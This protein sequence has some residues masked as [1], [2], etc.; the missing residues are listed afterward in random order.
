MSKIAKPHLYARVFRHDRYFAYLLLPPEVDHDIILLLFHL[1]S[2][3]TPAPYLSRY[4]FEFLVLIIAESSGFSQAL[5]KPLT[6]TVSKKRKKRCS[7][8]API[9]Y[10]PPEPLPSLPASLQP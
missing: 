7:V 8:R 9:S 2:R 10:L 5:I 1:S 6:L 3:R 4:H